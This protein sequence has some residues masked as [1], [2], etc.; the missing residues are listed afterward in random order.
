MSTTRVL[1]IDDD[2]AFRKSTAKLLEDA[3]CVIET[4][5]SGEA[6]L[7]RFAEVRFDAVLCDLMMQGMS[8]LELLPKLREI[9]PNVP[10]VMVTG[11][12]SIDSAVAAMKAGAIDYVTKPFNADEL[13][14]R[15][16]RAVEYERVRRELVLLQ[17]QFSQTK[18]L[19]GML[20]RSRAMEAVFTLANKVAA[21]DVTV[22]ILGETGTG[23][24]ML[25]QV[26]HAHSARAN[27]PFI[28]VNCAALTPTLLESE[29]FGHEKGAFTGAVE[30]RMGRFELAHGGTLFLDEI[31]ELTPELQTKLLEV[32]QEKRF[33]R[34]G[35]VADDSG[36]C[37]ADHRHESQS[38]GS[39]E[40]RVIP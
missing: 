27:R 30:R 10:I 32:V 18:G 17:E 16:M 36:G 6:A 13:R 37:A 23:K 39:R 20:G 24:G 4:S 9:D 3:F 26:I 35:G 40:G 28:S 2:L 33:E 15:M 29:L 5:A 19:G 21:S 25:A 7:A 1:L 14:L 8:G 11:H 34:V 31:G 12:G 22:L 38:G